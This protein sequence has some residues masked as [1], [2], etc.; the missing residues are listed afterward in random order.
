MKYEQFYNYVKF[1]DFTAFV[2]DDPKNRYVYSSR[3]VYDNVFEQTTNDTD[4][5]IVP[6][7]DLIEVKKVI[8]DNFLPE[9][10][11]AQNVEDK[12]YNEIE[13]R[14]HAGEAQVG[15]W[16]VHTK[17]GSEIIETTVYMLIL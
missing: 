4:F 5:T 1:G 13:R 10:E 3:E 17:Y 6:I 9:L 7:D 8:I 12:N 11:P 16:T 15:Y 2:Y 14:L